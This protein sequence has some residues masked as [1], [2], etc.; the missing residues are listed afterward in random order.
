MFNLFNWIGEQLGFSATTMHSYI[1]VITGLFIA[2]VITTLSLLA[3]RKLKNTED[4]VIP[5]KKL[6]IAGV[7]ELAVEAVLNLM[8][9][10]M[11]A[12]AEMY[13][14]IIGATFIYI[15]ISNLFGVIPGFIPPT[16]NIN[17]NAAI[18]VVIFLYYNVVGIKAQG[19]KHYLGHMAGPIIWLGPLIFCIELISHL[20]RPLSLSARLFGNMTGDHMVLEIFSNLTPLVIPIIFL[21]LGIFISFIQAFVF[22]LLSII[23]IALATEHEAH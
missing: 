10:I 17:T 3:Y 6:S 18:A 5:P 7:F 23:Y 4:C 13:F 20:V 14:P 16:D 2:L 19:L 22:S 15:L 11:G 9:E 21:G 12:R 1:H 8:R